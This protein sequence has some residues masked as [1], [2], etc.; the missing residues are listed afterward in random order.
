MK[1]YLRFGDLVERGIVNN[2]VTLSN[3]IRELGFPKGLLIGP[4][5]RVWLEEEVENWLAH[6]PAGKKPGRPRKGLKPGTRLAAANTTAP[7]S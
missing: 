5:T 2:R 3:W 4:N 1:S 6:R 7:I